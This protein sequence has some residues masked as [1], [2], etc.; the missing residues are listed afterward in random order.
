MAKSESWVANVFLPYDRSCITAYGMT[1]WKR[2]VERYA[3][4]YAGNSIDQCM[5]IHR[6]FTEMRK[7]GIA[8]RVEFGMARNTSWNL[9]WPYAAVATAEQA[10]LLIPGA[11]CIPY[12]LTYSLANPTGKGTTYRGLRMFE[13]M[14]PITVPVTA[15]PGSARSAGEGRAIVT[16][17]QVARRG[18]V[19]PG[20]C[21]LYDLTK[22]ESPRVRCEGLAMGRAV[23]FGA[24]DEIIDTVRLRLVFSSLPS[25]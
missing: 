20:D 18:D 21:Y 4:P 14:I 1:T 7:D 25:A 2:E 12:Y 16:R 19:R 8:T 23:Q 6:R 11:Q 17:D 5:R 10:Y 22:R 9:W 24:L 15:G 3:A 13:D